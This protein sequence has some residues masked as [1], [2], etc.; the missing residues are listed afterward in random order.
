ML[1]ENKPQPAPRGGNPRRVVL[2]AVG[3]TLWLGL[4]GGFCGV[5]VGPGFQDP[6]GADC[7]SRSIASAAA[8]D[9][10]TLAS[11]GAFLAANYRFTQRVDA[12]AGPDTVRT[13]VQGAGR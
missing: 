9:E 13:R 3:C 1:P 7:A 12:A 5:S 2:I 10:A 8:S 4:V 6:A 11:D